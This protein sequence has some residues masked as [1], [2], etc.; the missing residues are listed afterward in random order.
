M[1]VS[2]I[3]KGGLYLLGKSSDPKNIEAAILVFESFLDKPTLVK[4]GKELLENFKSTKTTKSEIARRLILELDKP[5]L[6][7]IVDRYPLNF[8]LEPGALQEMLE[9]TKTERLRWVEQEKLPIV[10]ERSFKYG[11]YPVYGMLE[12]IELSESGDIKNWREKH[13]QEVARNR[14]KAAQ[15]AAKS[16]S[17]CEKQE[18]DIFSLKTA[19]I[20]WEK[21]DPEKAKFLELAFWLYNA[22][23]Q[24][25]ILKDK[26]TR[27]RSK[28]EQY[29]AEAAELE[30][31]YLEHLSNLLAAPGINIIFNLVESPKALSW[32]QGNWRVA[33]EPPLKGFYSCSLCDR[34]N[35]TKFLFTVDRSTSI[36]PNPKKLPLVEIGNLGSKQELFFLKEIPRG[37]KIATRSTIIKAFKALNFDC[38]RITRQKQANF[39]RIAESAFPVY[40]KLQSKYKEQIKAIRIKAE[41]KL[42]ADRELWQ[43][44]N[45]ADYFELAFWARLA[46]RAAKS[47][48][49][50]GNKPKAKDFYAL[51]NQAI[52]ILNT[53]SLSKISFYRPPNPDKET[54]VNV[55]WYDL[56]DN[57]SGKIVEEDC[58][59]GRVKVVENII[60]EKDY[61]SLFSTELSHPALP[62]EYQFHTPFPLG[63]LIYPIAD[64]L[65]KEDHSDF[66]QIGEF[67]FGRPLNDREKI[68]FSSLQIEEKLQLVLSRFDLEEIAKIRNEKFKEINQQYEEKQ[69]RLQILNS[70]KIDFSIPEPVPNSNAL[71]KNIYEEI[72]RSGKQGKA[73][74]NELVDRLYEYVIIPREIKSLPEFEDKFIKDR[75]KKNWSLDKLDN[76]VAYHFKSNKAKKAH[77]KKLVSSR[78]KK[79]GYEE[80]VVAC[81]IVGIDTRKLIKGRICC[82]LNK[83]ELETKLFNVIKKGTFHNRLEELEEF[84]SNWQPTSNTKKEKH[85]KN[86]KEEVNNLI[87]SICKTFLELS[88]QQIFNLIYSWISSPQGEVEYTELDE[89]AENLGFKQEENSE[90]ELEDILPSSDSLRT[91][92]EALDFPNFYHQ[93]IKLAGFGLSQED[94]SEPPSDF[95]PGYNFLR[96]LKSYLKSQNEQKSSS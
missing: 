12:T 48:Q 63:K 47:F 3:E 85:N 34:T 77:L 51:K 60:R 89:I 27:A 14:K 5:Q 36:F 74:R 45:A 96:E 33:E 31:L 94:F 25:K 46:S 22:A 72:L 6:R 18:N 19:K 43:K 92:I 53:C 9:C 82:E 83:Q 52:G 42:K 70:F 17:S 29:Q 39:D 44:T 61:Y 79:F 64:A 58:Y 4:L 66:E 69:K 8:A 40:T 2:S 75:I 59:S 56:Q 37:P 23:Q 49:E 65:P 7:E 21:E 76:L 11:N 93:I 87:E 57:F 73:A 16:R 38:D 24:A 54:W 1:L 95:N 78:F 41:E 30:G 50:K 88:N 67:R 26:A 91:K 81:A 35:S 55:G 28:Q 15:K 62:E 68:A 13:K 71:I 80:A 20:T 10:G 90:G 84:L 86:K 32:E